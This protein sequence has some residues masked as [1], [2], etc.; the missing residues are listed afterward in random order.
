MP[1]LHARF[2]GLSTSALALGLA[3]LP[4]VPRA[5]HAQRGVAG[6]RSDSVTLHLLDAD[7]RTV[8]QAVSIYLDRPVVLG[9]VPSVRVSVETPQPIA[10]GDVAR[11]LRS[12]LESQNLSLV[13][14]SSGGVYR[15]QP[16]EQ[17][18]PATPP[19]PPPQQ[20]TQP[21]QQGGPLQL[22]VIRLR[23]ARASDVAA[24][25]NALYGRGNSLGELG[26]RTG[27]LS[28]DLQA[29]QVP[30]GMPQP[31]GQ[32]AGGPIVASR[33]AALTSEM[34]IVP[35]PRANSLLI[36]ATCA[37][38][39]LI[40]A[41]VEDIDVRP[42][43]VLIQVIIAEVRKDRSL[44][45]GADFE[46]PPTN[47]PHHP[48]TLVQGQNT[49]GSVGD[50]VMKVLGIG[51]NL[52]ARAGITAAAERGD[53]NILSRPVL[54]AANNEE[55]EINVGS[56]RPFVQVARVLATDNSA[57]DQVVQYR[58]VGT[59]LRVV[60]TISS[61]GYVALQVTQEVNAATTEQA[62]GAPV[63]SSRSV[64]TKLLIKDGQTIALGGLS[65]SQ[66][67]HRQ[68]GIP[69]LSSIP[70]LGALFGNVSRRESNTELFVFLTAR[71]IATDADVDRLTE[72][73]RKKAE[74][75]P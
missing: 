62:F 32:P 22:F 69:L 9:N 65:D 73:M 58:D 47:V 28:R 53:V 14:D 66:K 19:P 24:T 1:F 71:V 30:P 48:G 45:L 3:I 64:E 4:L 63:I 25:V 44:N 34:T 57:R 10:R 18:K 13:A 59:R 21:Q 17:P 60:P 67:D 33:G 11:L 40:K 38:F 31:G 12:V 43:Q 55:A 46:V 39:A 6:A 20:N 37:D 23:H 61:D 27:M 56:Q 68:G 2:Q 50:F 35:D 15:V 49:S 42:L 52:D 7:I 5:A 36:R 70:W 72:S 26:T 41:A 74:K 51:G 29:Q 16:K 8:V 54:L 75:I